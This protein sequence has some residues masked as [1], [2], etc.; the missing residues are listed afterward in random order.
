MNATILANQDGMM[1]RRR[2]AMRLRPR[3]TMFAHWGAALNS[4]SGLT[5]RTKT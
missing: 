5:N 1:P 2:A 3:S 4:P